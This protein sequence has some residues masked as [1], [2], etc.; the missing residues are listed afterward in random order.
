MDD[1]ILV[2]IITVSGSI[3]VAALT[4]Y[5]T[6]RHEIKV[7]WQREKIN[8]YKVLLSALSDL[9][10]DGTDKE[11]ANMRF[12]LATNTIALVAPQYV[13]DALMSFHDEV[14][15]SNPNKS[16]EEHDRLLI[17][18][19]LAIRKDIGLAAKDDVDTFTFHLIGS[20]PKK[21]GK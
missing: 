21:R 15:Y 3:L 4:F 14:K 13:I 10:T 8:H 12:S 20:A 16:P 17:Q 7:Q 19:L 9:A 2:A 1:T 18:L 6:K 5:L 11:D